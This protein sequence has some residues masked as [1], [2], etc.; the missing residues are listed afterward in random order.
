MA[1]IGAPGPGPIQNQASI[2]IDED[3]DHER[4]GQRLQ[5]VGPQRV[6]KRLQLPF[7]DDG[8]DAHPTVP[9]CGLPPEI[10][11]AAVSSRS[12]S[13]RRSTAARATGS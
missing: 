7:A 5:D 1:G 12:C 11:R 8:M 4:I 10:N 13:I 2:R 9:R 3:F 6:A